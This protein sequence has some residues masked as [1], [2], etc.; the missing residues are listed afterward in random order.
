MS[1][2]F[3]WLVSTA[4]LALL[5]AAVAA[6]SG[7]DTA[8]PPDT[9]PGA[10]CEAYAA[11]WCERRLACGAGAFEAGYRSVAECETQQTAA[12]TDR[13]DAT[14]SG[15]TAAVLAACTAD[16]AA[17]SCTTVL[18]YEASRCL[19]RGSLADEAAC[20]VDDQC[21]GGDCRLTYNADDCGRCMTLAK[22]GDSCTQDP[23]EEEQVICGPGL[24]CIN[25]ICKSAPLSGLG[26]TC[27]PSS[28]RRCLG[29]LYCDPSFVCVEPLAEGAACTELLGECNIAQ[30]LFCDPEGL[31]CR[32]AP[33]HDVGGTCYPIGTPG[34]AGCGPGAWCGPGFICKAFVEAG[35]ACDLD[36][37]CNV[38]L[39]CAANGTCVDVSEL[40]C[41]GGTVDPG[42]KPVDTRP[43][44]F[45]I[46]PA[47]V[48]VSLDCLDPAA[49]TAA[50]E[51]TAR[52]K[53]ETEA[54]LQGRVE[55]SR[56]KLPTGLEL[57]F[58]VVPI[59]TGVLQPDLGVAV[60]HIALRPVP[61]A[62]CDACNAPPTQT[63]GLKVEV[64]ALGIV[65]TYVSEGTIQ[66]PLGTFGAKVQGGPGTK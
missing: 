54:P 15:L 21:A 19:V 6:C 50:L 37:F 22:A 49:A 3:A 9:T 12:C 29:N 55:S 30:N 23:D 1:P 10:D 64:S 56:V 39:A 18:D 35:G 63:A 65:A 61:A 20:L 24:Q 59:S 52:Y 53:N 5:A 45:D 58:D 57:A 34:G 7:S 40:T 41:A 4:L 27:E 11:T 43:L 60:T 33:M 2:R 48:S 36:A 31:V 32:K 62:A 47:G 25:G 42:D 17:A 8:P 14:G 66:C 16:L 38:N 44:T 28:F 46:P 51:Y 26:E 13:R